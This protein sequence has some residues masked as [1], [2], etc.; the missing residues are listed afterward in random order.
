MDPSL[1]ELTSLPCHHTE[2]GG[3]YDLGKTWPPP[4]GQLSPIILVLIMHVGVYT[5]WKRVLKWGLKIEGASNETKTKKKV[6]KN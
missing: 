6:I 3:I 4:L 2:E 1:I 5:V